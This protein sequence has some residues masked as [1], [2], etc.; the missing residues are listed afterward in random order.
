M[1][2]SKTGFPRSRSEG[3]RRCRCS[4]STPST[5]SRTSTA[6]KNDNCNSDRRYDHQRYDA[7]STKSQVEHFTRREAGTLKDHT[8][9]TSR[10]LKLF[11]TPTSPVCHAPICYALCTRVT[12]SHTPSPYLCD[13]IYGC[14]LNRVLQCRYTCYVCKPFDL[15]NPPIAYLVVV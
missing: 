13:V 8:Q 5:T 14:P 2:Q 6:D 11:L 3:G 1:N 7:S 4:T 9:M 12:Q 15:S 10:K